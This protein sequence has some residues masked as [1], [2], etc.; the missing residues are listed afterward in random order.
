[1]WGCQRKTCGVHVS[2]STMWV[3][4]MGSRCHLARPRAGFVNIK[5]RGP[6]FM[7]QNNASALLSLRRLPYKLG[8]FVL[9]QTS[10]GGNSSTYGFLCAVLRLRQTQSQVINGK[11]GFPLEA[12]SLAHCSILCVI[13]TECGC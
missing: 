4:G 13:A 11:V 5:A 12:A 10:L 9:T 2:L 1:M 8:A 6:D 7:T 3:L